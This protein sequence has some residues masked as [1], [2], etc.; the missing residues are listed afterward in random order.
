MAA[1]GLVRIICLASLMSLLFPAPSPASGRWHAR[2]MVISERG[3][4]ATSQTLASQAAAQVL[5]RGGNAVDAAIAANAALT[6]VEPMMNGMGGDLFVLYR[7]AKSGKVIGLNASGWSPKA[8][9]LEAMRRKGRREMPQQGI[10]SATVPGCVDG[11]E[12]LHKAHGVLAWKDL[13]QPAIYYAEQGFPVTEWIQG[14]WTDAVFKLRGDDYAAKLFLVD[15]MAPAVGDVFRNPDLAK[16]L[17]LVATQGADAFYRGDIAKGILATSKK[18]GGLFEASD[19]SEFSSEWVEPVTTDYRGWTVYELP[20][21]GQGMAALSMLN[22]MERF[23]L[24]RYRHDSPEA[25]HWKIEAQKLAYQDLERYNGD[26][27]FSKIPVSQLISKQYAAKRAELVDEKRARCDVEPGDPM[28]GTGDTI[29]LT[30]VDR[31]GNIVSLI[32]SIFLSFGSGVA[33]EGYGFHLH[34]RG[35]LFVLE[36]DHPNVAAPRKR[37][38]HTIIPGLMEKGDSHIGFGIMGGLNQAQA[39]AQFVSNIVDED[40][41]I[42]QALE[43]ARFTKLDFGRGCGV[44]VESRIPEDSRKALE[45]KG[46]ILSVEAEFASPMGGGQAVQFDSN[47]GIKYGASSPRKDGAAVPEPDPYFK[48]ESQ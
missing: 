32:Q 7:E 17:R 12:M 37:P 43:A 24:G 15:G 27:R 3:I 39:H 41:N 45:R 1:M 35:A 8:L 47:T 5:A 11:W 44:I 36:E 23:P 9:T 48:G 13:F 21:N 22:I 28:S 31:E 16:S 2:S 29:Y 46:H 25:L 42:Q 26:P 40:M 19:L 33:V 4:A 34:N 30:V 10:L 38:F 18:L 6:V 14:Y 20:P